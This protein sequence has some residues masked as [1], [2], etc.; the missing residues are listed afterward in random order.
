MKPFFLIAILLIPVLGLFQFANARQ[1]DTAF[2][3]TGAY[4]MSDGSKLI[5]TPA[6]G[7]NLRYRRPDGTSRRLFAQADGSYLSGQGWAN[8]QS[9]DVFTTIDCAAGTVRFTEKGI[10]TTGKR[11]H[12]P[13]ISTPFP[14]KGI[15]LYGE[16]FLPAGST[17]KAVVVLQFG[18]GR[19]SAITYNF[20][21]YLL[22]LQDIAVFVFDKRGTGKSGGNYTANF[23]TMAGDMAAAVKAVKGIPAV[24]G[25]PVGIMGESQGGWVVPAT[26]SLTAVDFV[27]SSYGLA[28]S[29][30]EE[31]R[32]EV[33]HDL[34][35]KKYSSQVIAQALQ[36]VEATDRWFMSGLTKGQEQLDSLRAL[37]GAE[38]W[39]KELKG[40][41]TGLLANG[42]K[43]DLELARNAFSFDIELK[44]DP[45]PALYKVN[46][47][48][49]WVIAGKDTEAPNQETIRRLKELQKKGSHLDLVIFPN[50]DHGIIEVAET[51]AGVEMLGRH[52]PGYFDL[53][54]DWILT[55]RIK[56]Q[57]GDAIQLPYKAK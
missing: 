31:N 12:L 16:L 13:V 19:E 17:A 20:L 14:N 47:P 55:R 15:N 54:Q 10:T 26:A 1:A 38:K 9:P 24:K 30:S 49:L 22:P 43:E 8:K 28:I 46:K 57:Y 45:M 56:K 50:A 48:M 41:Y 21:Q 18:S 40:D 35:E 27:I 53:L 6:D 42:S 39:Y 29:P 52:S 25:L 33:L 23:A 37:Y 32:Q 11:V 3:R 5:I 4:A 51:P 36:V 2:C 44:Y 34:H 7:A